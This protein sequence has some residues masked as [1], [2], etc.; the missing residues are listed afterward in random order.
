[1][2]TCSV[3]EKCT[4]TDAK[5][6]HNFSPDE[7][8]SSWE[9]FENPN[10]KL[11]EKLAVSSVAPEEADSTTSKHC[12][13]GFKKPDCESDPAQPSSESSKFINLYEQYLS[14]KQSLNSRTK[15]HH[16][17]VNN[18]SRAL[19][20]WF[21]T[22]GHDYSHRLEQVRDSL[23]RCSVEVPVDDQ[24]FTFTS[25]TH[26]KRQ[27][28]VD[29]VCLAACKILD[30]CDLLKSWQQDHV[31]N[32]LERK[33]RI[34]EANKEDD[35]ELDNTRLEISNE[36]KRKRNTLESLK[37]KWSQLNITILGLKAKLVKLDLSVSKK[38]DD[39]NGGTE[40]DEEDPL[41][42]FMSNLDKKTGLTL[43]DKIEKSRLKSQISTLE[44]EQEEI[45][46]TINE[47]T[48]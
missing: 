9:D 5:Y 2:R 26:P 27:T 37:T 16:L 3:S 39:N 13:W 44:R 48:T 6:R 43:N 18:P 14:D 42:A 35:I 45:G 17:Y 22:E 19:H 32:D 4:T 41:D 7:M 23:Y 46:E 47:L 40:S 28:A 20:E 29:E 8:A 15:N 34:D 25:E 36:P 21:D 31:V 33:R 1:M 24:D 38:N 11:T 10:T 12:D 30:E